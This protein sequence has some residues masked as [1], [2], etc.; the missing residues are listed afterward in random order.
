MGSKFLRSSGT[1]TIIICWWR[2][3]R[4]E[5]KYLNICIIT[6]ITINTIVIAHNEHGWR[7]RR[8][9]DPIISFTIVIVKVTFNS[10]N[11]ILFQIEMKITI[12][13]K[14]ICSNCPIAERWS[15][16]TTAIRNQNNLSLEDDLRTCR[17]C[18]CKWHHAFK[19][20]CKCISFRCQLAVRI[21]Q[22]FLAQ[23]LRLQ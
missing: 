1:S 5:T 20:I 21:L 6:L 7:V 2:R 11:N 9:E 12:R 19:C 13:R 14:M 4:Q 16:I 23:L 15:L 18:I 3:S 10:N 17:E 22:H 8:K